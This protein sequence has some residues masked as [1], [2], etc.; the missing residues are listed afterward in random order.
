MGNSVKIILSTICLTFFA[1]VYAV[2]T[3]NKSAIARAS[4]IIDAI[5]ITH[6]DDGGTNI[7]VRGLIKGDGVP[8]YI[9]GIVPEKRN[10]QMTN[11]SANSFLKLNQR[12]IIF[13]FDHFFA[14]HDYVFPVYK[15]NDTLFCDCPEGDSIRS[16]AVS[17]FKRIIQSQLS[18]QKPADEPKDYRTLAIE[19]YDEADAELNQTYKQLVNH[20]KNYDHTSDIKQQWLQQLKYS[21]RAWIDFRDKD[22]QQFEY[23]WFGG[24]GMSSAVIGWKTRLTRERTKHLQE[25]LSE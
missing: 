20:I 16:M 4:Q 11:L 5:I 23:I 25:I 6:Y 14:D 3:D 9:N 13:V 7:D 8:K 18:M 10:K 21:Q 22:A 24:S 15:K 12:Y 17:E 2:E 1:K 19:A